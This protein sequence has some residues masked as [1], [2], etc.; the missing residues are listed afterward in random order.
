MS[1]LRIA[2]RDAVDGSDEHVDLML[3]EVGFAGSGVER[4]AALVHLFLQGLEV[5][6]LFLGLRAPVVFV[7]GVHGSG[8]VPV[9]GD[10]AK[11][12][13][14]DA[15]DDFVRHFS[16]VGVVVGL[17]EL[18]ELDVCGEGLLCGEGLRGRGRLGRGRFGHEWSYSMD[19]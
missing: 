18:D 14:G 13:F 9:F 3:A 17:F 1:A 12:D 19:G 6:V 15:V 10:C 7:P 2:G 11:V 4:F 5:A 16:V 8:A